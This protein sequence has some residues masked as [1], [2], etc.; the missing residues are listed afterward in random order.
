MIR[1]LVGILAFVINQVYIN[2]Y[3]DGNLYMFD[4]FQASRKPEE[5]RPKIDNLYDVFMAIRD[6]E[7][8]HV[9]TMIARQHPDAQLMLQSPHTACAIGGTASNE[10]ND[11]AFAA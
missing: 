8:E 10:T 3:R 11:E 5:R 4:E 9:K 7:S 6:D 1:L 2:Y